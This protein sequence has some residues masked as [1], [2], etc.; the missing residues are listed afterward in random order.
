MKPADN[1]YYFD[2]IKNEQNLKS[3]TRQVYVHSLNSILRHVHVDPSSPPPTLDQVL[4]N[5]DL[6]Y[7]LI[8]K[9]ATAVRN[10]RI[11]V[12]GK[13]RIQPPSDAQGTIRTQV[14]TLVSL[15][16]YSHFKER[17][18]DKYRAWY[19]YFD[20]LNKAMEQREDNNLPT[21]ATEMMWHEILQR[22]DQYEPGSQEHVVLGLYTYI[23]PRRQTDYYNLARTPQI[24]ETNPEHYTGY[25]DLKSTPPM[26]KVTQFKTHDVY[27]DYE[28]PLPKELSN[29]ITIF[30]ADKDSRSKKK[31]KPKQ[32]YLFAKLNGDPY[33]TIAS[34]TDA[35]NNVI[36][37]ALDNPRT[38]VNTLRHAASSYVAT[39]T[40][41]LRG[42]KKRWATAMGH[43]LA[44]QG[45]YVIARIEE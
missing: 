16:K 35:N 27:S 43:S 42:E 30:L 8:V 9:G 4:K 13:W 7:P 37:R 44:M 3:N 23:P 20:E 19:K 15:M 24:Y 6:Y 26:L 33:P 39:S 2:I 31:G 28:T 17:Q 25:L 41:M 12:G 38:S 5:A 32:R 40:T 10:H 34:F 18:P 22:R 21:A 29:S 14:K 1:E 45:H 36:K 11:Q